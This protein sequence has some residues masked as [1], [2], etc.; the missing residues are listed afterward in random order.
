M[1]FWEERRLKKVRIYRR[2]LQ[3]SRKDVPRELSEQKEEPRSDCL[4]EF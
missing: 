1:N 4:S 2:G 3:M